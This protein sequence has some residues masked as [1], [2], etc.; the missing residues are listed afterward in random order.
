[1]ASVL[2]YLL[3]SELSTERTQTLKDHWDQYYNWAPP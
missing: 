2:V 3:T 1:M